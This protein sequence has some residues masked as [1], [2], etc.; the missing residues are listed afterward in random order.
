MVSRVTN[1][2]LDCMYS[3]SVI[4][5]AV[6]VNHDKTIRVSSRLESAGAGWL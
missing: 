6:S 2:L 1:H 5:G 3:E 4:R